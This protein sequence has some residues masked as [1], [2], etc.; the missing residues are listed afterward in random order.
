MVQINAKP[1]AGFDRPIEMLM[2][3]HR[4]IEHFLDVM[5]RVVELYSG[6]ALDADGRRAIEASRQYFAHSAPHHTA[7]EEQSLFPRMQ[8]AG[9]SE[10]IEGRQ[11]DRL[12]RDHET[13]EKLHKRID[14]LLDE[15]V[16]SGKPLPESKR[17]S[18][19]EDL[20]EVRGLYADHIGVEEQQVFPLAARLLGDRE[21]REIGTEMRTRRGLAPESGGGI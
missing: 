4:R 21:L 12:R 7:D 8:S 19:R 16:A 3:C 20:T 17:D 10:A 18:L 13:A 5:I 11:L 1:L 15:W 14:Q 2:D 9:A 6:R